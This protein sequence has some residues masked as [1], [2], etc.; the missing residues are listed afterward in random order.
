VL[1][2][3]V[4]LTIACNT[5]ANAA[6]R[7]AQMSASQATVMREVQHAKALISIGDPK[8]LN[9]LKSAIFAMQSTF[10][11]YAF[12]AKNLIEQRRTLVRDWAEIFKV[13]EQAY[14]PT[15]DPS[16]HD[17]LPTNCVIPPG[18]LSCGADPREIKDRTSRAAYIAEIRANDM[19]LKQTF[20]YHEISNIDQLA[21]AS[22]ESSLS[23]LA[24]CEPQKS[25][26]DFVALDKIIQ[27]TG[28]SE[29]R[30][31]TLDSWFYGR[32]SP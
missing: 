10:D 27:E 26:G 20:Y 4:C 6:L 1:L 25:P 21:M 31:I 23:V 24:Q 19:K 28:L 2:A 5:S 32:S 22:L 30:R 8:S 16:D 11:V 17:D 13:I 9:E 18:G 3:A 29:E 7:A 15:F 14:D 12:T